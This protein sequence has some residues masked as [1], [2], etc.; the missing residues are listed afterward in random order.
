MLANLHSDYSVLYHDLLGEEVGTYRG[1]VAGAEFLV[2][3]PGNMSKKP[4][5]GKNK[6]DH[7]GLDLLTYWFIKL[8]F[9]TP[10]S[11]RMMTWVE[12]LMFSFLKATL[13]RHTFKRIFFRDA[14]TYTLA[15]NARPTRQRT[16]G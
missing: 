16:P 5:R 13:E 3:L 15:P 11:P 7:T 12:A 4:N 8:V 6:T 9:P 1:F 10:L 2:D 14:M